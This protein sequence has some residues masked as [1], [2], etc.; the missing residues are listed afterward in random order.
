MSGCDNKPE[1]LCVVYNGQ[2]IIGWCQTWQEADYICEKMSTLQWEMKNKLKT[3]RGLSQI[4]AS[5]I[6]AHVE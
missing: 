4:I 1:K 5:V 6:C 3:P 2:T